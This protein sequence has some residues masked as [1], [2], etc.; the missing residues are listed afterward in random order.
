MTEGMNVR[1]SAF[2]VVAMGAWRNISDIAC[3]DG[4]S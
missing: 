2:E 3:A 1:P 4:T